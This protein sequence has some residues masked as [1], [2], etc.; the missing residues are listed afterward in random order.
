LHELLE[1]ESLCDAKQVA[2]LVHNEP[3]VAAALLRCANSAAFGGLRA[4]TDLGQ[5]VARLGLKRVSTLVTAVQV[6]GN[7]SSESAEKNELLNRLWDHAVACAL[8]ARRLAS[9]GGRDVEEAFL[10]GLLHDCGK[11]L[12][13]KSVDH[14]ES[15]DDSLIIT[16]P[17]IDELMTVMHT[18]LGHGL[19]TAWNLPE[20]ICNVA[21]HHEDAEQGEKAPLITAVQAANA[22]SKKLGFHLEPNPDLNLL[23]E[24]ALERLEIA[25]IELATLMVD[26]EDEI[27][28]VR[29][30]F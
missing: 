1:D 15:T 25:D 20:P 12:V 17:V 29:E 13:L 30:L 11:L 19:L 14:L 27:H 8:V 24:P 16:R 2:D 10:A 23:E 5:A 18:E 22:I 9:R 26:L 6:R 28:A 7:F 21:L 4:I 3:A